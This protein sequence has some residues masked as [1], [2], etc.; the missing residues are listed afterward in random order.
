VHTHWKAEVAAFGALAAVGVGSL[1]A[2]IALGQRA[3]SAADQLAADSGQGINMFDAGRQSLYAD[4]Q[5]SATAATA[6]YAIGGVLVAGSVVAAVLGFRD[7][8]RERRVTATAGG[9]ACAF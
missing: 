2:A 8:A 1:V 3:S 9:L 4:G 7:R 6:L 5:H